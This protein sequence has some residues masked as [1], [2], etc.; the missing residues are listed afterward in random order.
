V[1][2]GPDIVCARGGGGRVENGR[3]TKGEREE[4]ERRGR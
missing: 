1:Y 2:V 4:E 3:M